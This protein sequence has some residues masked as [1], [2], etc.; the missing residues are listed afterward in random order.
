M[1]GRVNREELKVRLCDACNSS[2]FT[3]NFSLYSRFSQV[4]K[5]DHHLTARQSPRGTLVAHMLKG[6]EQSVGRGDVLVQQAQ[7]RG[8]RCAGEVELGKLA[9]GEGLNHMF[10]VESLAC[11][12]MRD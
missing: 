9:F 1:E 12:V 2:L 11:S 4:F 6:R 3:L 5:D 8:A 10:S 7:G